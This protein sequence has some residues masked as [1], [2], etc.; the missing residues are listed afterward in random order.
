[1]KR[2][3]FLNTMGKA[4]VALAGS[5]ALFNLIQGC[6][7]SQNKRWNIVFILSDDHGW[8]QVGYHGSEFYE[9][10]N[11][12]R[13]AAEGMQ[14]TEAYAAAP[15][16]S[17]TRAAIMTGKYPA[18]L[19]LTDYIPGSPY[20]YAKAKTPQQVPCLPLE[21]VTI[22]EVLKDNGYIT[23]HFGKWHL[24]TDYNYQPGRP[25]DPGSQGFDVVLTNVK[26]EEN[27]DPEKDAHH[28][29]EITTHAIKF[30]EENKDRPFFCYVAHHVPHRPIMEQASLIAK[31]RAKPGA[32]LPQNNPIMGAMIERMDWGI[33]QILNKLDELKLTDKTIVV[34]VSDNGGLAQLQSQYPLRMGKA[35]IFDG[36]LRVPMVIRWPGVVQPGSK[37]TTPV[38]SIDFF[39][40]L[41]EAVGIQH[42]VKDIDGI[43][44]VPALRGTGDIKRDAIYFHYPHYHHQGY[45][46]AGAVRAGDYKLIEWYEATLWDE[47]NQVSLYNVREDMGETRDLAKEMPELAAKLRE[48]LRQWRKAVAAQEMTR[49]PNYDPDKADWRFVDRKE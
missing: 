4:T 8:N 16:C 45:K 11:I 44:L 31:Y 2:R 42:Q 38:I 19:H 26:P 35:T 33:G 37:C 22:A 39:P 48:Q 40:T 20:P 1:M 5:N 7:T 23:G 12:D 24:S 29:V 25:F 18:R 21:E 49:N 15:V 46:P 13:L 32:D 10:P 6:S 34:F 28:V 30:I 36:G 14:F 43:S 27:A 41:L 17:P 3:D 47:E 9:T